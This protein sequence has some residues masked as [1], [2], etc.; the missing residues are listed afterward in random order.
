MTCGWRW[1]RIGCVGVGDGWTVDAGAT[2]RRFGPA[3]CEGG[4]HSWG[5]SAATALSFPF[6]FRCWCLSAPLFSRLSISFNPR[7]TVCAAQSLEGTR[8][9]PN[10]HLV[11]EFSSSPLPCAICSA[12]VSPSPRVRQAVKGKS[13]EFCLRAQTCKLSPGR[14]GRG[15]LRVKKSC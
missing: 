4:R 10:L 5:A 6:P 8:R 13:P 14:E 2:Y 11:E 9:T 1:M 3:V 12:L 7:R 15:F